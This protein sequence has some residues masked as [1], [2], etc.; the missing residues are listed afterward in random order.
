V[1]EAMHGARPALV[2]G[3]GAGANERAG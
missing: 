1:P 3:E 2:V